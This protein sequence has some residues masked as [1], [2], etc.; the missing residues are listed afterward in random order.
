MVQEQLNTLLQMFEPALMDIFECYATQY[1][2]RLKKAGLFTSG[3]SKRVIG[4]VE[5]FQFALD[6]AGRYFHDAQAV[7]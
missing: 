6:R 7:F 1:D 5:L 2:N 4:F 3:S